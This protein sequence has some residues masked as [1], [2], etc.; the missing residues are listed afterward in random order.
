ML[1]AAG[2]PEVVH[3]AGES[4]EQGADPFEPRRDRHRR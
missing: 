1:P 3:L 2:R 4:V